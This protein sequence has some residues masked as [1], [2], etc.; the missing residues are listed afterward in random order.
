M[1]LYLESGGWRIVVLSVES[2][3]DGCEKKQNEFRMKA[4]IWL[5]Y[6]EGISADFGM[7]LFCPSV[8]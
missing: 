7:P 8:D 4:H 5:N 2:R 6:I 3:S 1:V